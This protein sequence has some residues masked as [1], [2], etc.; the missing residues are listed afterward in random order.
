MSF[1]RNIGITEEQRMALA[2]YRIKY[3][4][5]SN[6]DIIKEQWI[7]LLKDEEV[8]KAEDVEL[9]KCIYSSKECHPCTSSQAT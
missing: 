8:I 7:I 1:D 9:L 2:N 6:V 3:E 4:H 5:T